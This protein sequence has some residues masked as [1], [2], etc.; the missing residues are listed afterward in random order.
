MAKSAFNLSTAEARSVQAVCDHGCNKA[1]AK[2]LGI[3]VRTLEAQLWKAK[4][5]AGYATRLEFLL[6]WDRAHRA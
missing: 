1:A 5:K 2:A 6:A 4:A 3:S